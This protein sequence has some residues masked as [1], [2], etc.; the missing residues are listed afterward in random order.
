MPVSGPS[1]TNRTVRT[2]CVKQQ[3]IVLMGIKLCDP[4][5]FVARLPDG[6]REKLRSNRSYRAP[7]LRIPNGVLDAPLEDILAAIMS[8]SLGASSV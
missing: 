8:Y 7:E 6:E 2:S 1:R 4:D 3:P 5:G